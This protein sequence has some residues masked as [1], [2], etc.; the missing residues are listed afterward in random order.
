MPAAPNDYDKFARP[1]AADNDVNLSIARYEGPAIRALAGDV[2]G[3]RVLDAGCGS[4]SLA[5]HLHPSPVHGSRAGGR[6]RLL[7]DQRDHR[8]VAQ[9]SYSSSTSRCTSPTSVIT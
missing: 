5:D 9:V 8:P 1:Y 3:R 2:A 4:G 7:R 6:H